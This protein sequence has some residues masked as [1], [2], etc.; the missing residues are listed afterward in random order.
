MARLWRVR[1]RATFAAIRRDGV[2]RRVGPVVITRLDDGSVP[3]RVAYAI[4]RPVGNAAERNR[5]RR[6]LRALVADAAPT[7]G[8]YLVGA[9]RAAV[10]ASHQELRDLVTEGLS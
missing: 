7:P 5:L 9:G 1:D 6:R 10:T 4:G 8:T 3:P 2:R